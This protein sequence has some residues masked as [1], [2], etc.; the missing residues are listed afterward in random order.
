MYTSLHDFSAGNTRM[1]AL[2][3][4]SLSVSYRDHMRLQPGPLDGVFQEAVQ[5][6][7][8]IVQLTTLGRTTR[9]ILVL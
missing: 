3:R 9:P 2:R 5:T 7:W 4:T 8:V 6:R 1:A